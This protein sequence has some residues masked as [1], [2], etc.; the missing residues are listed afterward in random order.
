MVHFRTIVYPLSA[1]SAGFARFFALLVDFNHIVVLPSV[2]AAYFALMN[3]EVTQ[4][5]RIRLVAEHSYF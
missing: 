4:N 5:L 1:E 2:T 3:E